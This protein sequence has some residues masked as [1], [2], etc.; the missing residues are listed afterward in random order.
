[1]SPLTLGCTLQAPL[2]LCR[3]HGTLKDQMVDDEIATFVG[4]FTWYLRSFINFT[5]QNAGDQGKRK[6]AE[7]HVAGYPYSALCTRLR[8]FSA[9]Q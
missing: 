2:G 9:F 1:M 7:E 4:L 5:R 3:C 6:T 8:D